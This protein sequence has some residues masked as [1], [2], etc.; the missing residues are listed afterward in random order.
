MNI[1]NVTKTCHET[2]INTCIKSI[3]QRKVNAPKYWNMSFLLTHVT[4]K[5]KAQQSVLNLVEFAIFAN[6]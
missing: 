1:D 2:H 6:N 4:L 3:I 5:P